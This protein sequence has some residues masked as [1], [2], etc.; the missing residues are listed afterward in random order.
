MNRKRLALA[1]LILFDLLVLPS[2][3]RIPQM[4][5]DH[6]LNAASVWVAN[7]NILQAAKL[8]VTDPKIRQL[9]ILCQ[10]LLFVIALSWFWKDLPSKR[11]RVKEGVGGPEAAGMG[12][13][14]TS[15][16]Q[17]EKETTQSTTVWHF[18]QAVA[19]G[20]IILG[21]ILQ[22]AMAWIVDQDLHTL[23]IGATRSGKTRRLLFPTLWMLAHAGESMILTDPKGELHHRSSLFLRKKGYDVVVLDFR[24]PG[25][26]NRWNPMF[27]VVE[28]LDKGDVVEATQQAW[29]IAHMFVYQKPGAE[30]SEPIWNNGAES[31]I[32]ALILAVAME[33]PAT[34]QKHLTSVYKTLAELGESQK[35]KVGSA[36][37]DY[38]PLNEYFKQLPLDHPARDAFATA[39]L[40][41]E[42]TR[43]SFYATCAS[44]LRLFS[45]PSISHLTGSQDHR[46]EDVGNKKTAAFL[47]IP[48]D[49]TTRHSLAALYIDQTYKALVKLANQQGGRVP[50]RVNNL[51]DEFGNM[52]MIKDFST[53]LTVSGGRGIRW[54]LIVQDFNQLK[55]AYPDTWETIIGNC[56]TTIYLRTQHTGTAK[57]ISEMCG[58][59]TIQT[60]N[61]SVQ[62][63]GIDASHGQ[64]SGLTG[65]DLL[66][67]D[68][69]LRWPK[70]QALV[71]RGGEFPARL[72]LPDLS[73]W[74]ADKELI[75]LGGE[76]P[77]VIEKIPVFV[78]GIQT[79]AEND[80][81][82]GGDHET[83]TEQ[84]PE[85]LLME[86]IE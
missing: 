41:P 55:A 36:L 46:L 8:V 75:P 52:P 33:A 13:F 9:W 17:S 61:S 47:V 16:W 7:F 62:I 86:T 5:A 60:D 50:I 78:P 51:L 63:R 56:Q 80:E 23:I 2:A 35:V 38:V 39:R 19:R 73:Q 70:D 84:Y 76:E 42:R 77:R 65:R 54:N 28:A 15:R 53:K 83:D 26:G 32:A 37:L 25:R 74:P 3:L 18:K 48:D 30:K 64:S 29:S 6:A 68:E 43:G 12:Q 22:K 71:L 79:D 1:V 14:G 49:D 67:M 59:Y 24:E 27:P 34:N 57:R 69:V 66:T 11:N 82:V 85:P 44:L 21:V 40:A 81:R 10:P 58:K 31:V 4:V 45:D 72:P 20:G